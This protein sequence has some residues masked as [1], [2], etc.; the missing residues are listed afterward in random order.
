M[1]ITFGVCVEIRDS[2]PCPYVVTIYGIRI[3]PWFTIYRGEKSIENIT[4]C[5]VIWHNSDPIYG[6]HIRTRITVPY[7]NADP[8]S[9]IHTGFQERTITKFFVRRSIWDHNQTG[10]DILYVWGFYILPSSKCRGLNG[11]NQ[12]YGCG[13]CQNVSVLFSRLC[14]TSFFLT[15]I[16]SK[17]F[18]QRSLWSATLAAC[19]ALLICVLRIQE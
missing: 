16:C 5:L 17:T 10:V 12:V 11:S 7:L 8:K 3:G 13:Q 4:A 6:H 1:D 14:I 19:E 2:Y 18:S 15:S 9:D